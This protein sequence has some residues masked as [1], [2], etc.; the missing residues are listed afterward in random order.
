M[1]S[2]VLTLAD[3]YVDALTE[4]LHNPSETSL[5][6]AYE[7]GREAINH[8]MG[9]LDLLAVHHEAMKQW[10]PRARSGVEAAVVAD[11]AAE[12]L[13]EAAA[14][15]EMALLGFQNANDSLR[16]LNAR[17]E[18]EVASRTEQILDANARLRHGDVERRRL[19]RKLNQ[20]QEEERKLLANALHDDTVQ[21]L[22]AAMLRLD[23]LGQR[24]SDPK[25]EADLRALSEQ[26]VDAIKRC[27]HLLFV[28]RPPAL[29]RDGLKA[30]VDELVQRAITESDIRASLEYDCEGEPEEHVNTVVFRVLDEAIRNAQKHSKAATLEIEISDL[31]HGIDVICRDD[32]EGFDLGSVDQARPGHLGLSSMRERV[33]IVGGTW[34]LKSAPGQG[35]EVHFWM[36]LGLSD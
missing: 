13:N 36:P 18:S 11:A 24:Q 10:L 31:M 2:K 21:I 20:A 29:D 9:M 30:A 4:H 7:L 22:T 28:L 1:S 34:E 33:E 26:L 35:T 16:G 5:S 12:F 6:R 25:V 3:P 17:L 15:M 8:G 14:P 23:M 19:L 32:G 27:R